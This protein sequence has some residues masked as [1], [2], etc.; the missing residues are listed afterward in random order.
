MKTDAPVLIRQNNGRFLFKSYFELIGSPN[1]SNRID[2]PV[3]KSIS[4]FTFDYYNTL[5]RIP[6]ETRQIIEYN[7]K[8]RIPIIRFNNPEISDED[9]LS[10]AIKDECVYYRMLSSEEK[11]KYK[12]GILDDYMPDSLTP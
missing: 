8:L 4:C 3:G 2:A 9:I 5:E 11:R 6:F 1:G 7:S 10:I 12:E